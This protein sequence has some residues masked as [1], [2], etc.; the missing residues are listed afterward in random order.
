M[1]KLGREGGGGAA[2]PR[3]SVAAQAAAQVAAGAAAQVA[4]WA[5]VGAL[6]WAGGC[7]VA[8]CCCRMSSTSLSCTA[9]IV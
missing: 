7:R 8:S 2:R 3:R 6:S 5:A 4:G 9:E 1:T